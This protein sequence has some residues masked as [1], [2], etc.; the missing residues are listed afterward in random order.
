MG[1]NPLATQNGIAN[2]KRIPHT[3]IPFNSMVTK[4]A[5]RVLKSPVIFKIK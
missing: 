4:S 2:S 5:L 3:W 1:R